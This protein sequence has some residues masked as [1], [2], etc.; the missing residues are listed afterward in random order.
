M[1]LIMLDHSSTP[2]DK[3]RD[4]EVDV[5]KDNVP[6]DSDRFLDWKIIPR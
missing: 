1:K 3:M 5:I 2:F 4:A 6:E